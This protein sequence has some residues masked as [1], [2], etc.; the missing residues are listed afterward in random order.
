MTF[1]HVLGFMCFIFNSM[2]YAYS[3]TLKTTITSEAFVYSSTEHVL[4]SHQIKYVDDTTA[5]FA[6]DTENYCDENIYD[7]FNRLYN[8]KFTFDGKLTSDIW[9][10]SANGVTFINQLR[11]QYIKLE[12]HVWTLI[13]LQLNANNCRIDLF[14]LVRV[15]NSWLL[16]GNFRENAIDLNLFDAHDE[17]L[18]DC[19]RTVNRSVQRAQQTYLN[20]RKLLS[21]PENELD[22]MYIV[23]DHLDLR[24][25]LDDIYKYI[26]SNENYFRSVSRLYACRFTK[27]RFI[28]ERNDFSLT[29]FHRSSIF[30]FQY[31]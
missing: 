24:H 10:Q 21:D 6:I 12:Q 11:Q 16:N 15:S 23:Q 8:L 31:F 2:Y 4:N 9:T 17:I 3:D 1:I 25:T 26:S 7:F 22:I 27:Q 18:F 28:L 29:H 13:G 30:S 14:E 19:I 20:D 5:E